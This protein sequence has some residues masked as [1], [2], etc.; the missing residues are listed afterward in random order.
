[1]LELFSDL[2]SIKVPKHRRTYQITNFERPLDYRPREHLPE[3]DGVVALDL[4]TH[5]PGL[6][7][8]RGSSWVRAGEGKI[9]GIGIGGSSGNADERFYLPVAHAGGNGDAERYFRWLAGQ[10]A[11]PSVSFVY[12]N[13]P[14]DLGW[15]SKRHGIEFANAP[16]DVQAMAALL[17]ETRYSYSLDA[18]G[19]DHLGRGKNDDD[20]K[21]ACLQGR[22]IDPMSRMDLVPAWLAEKYGL[23][24]ID[25]TIGLFNHLMPMIQR[26]GLGRVLGLERECALVAVDMKALGVRVDLDRA[27]R[28]E[29]EFSLRRAEALKRV[30]DLTGVHTSAS[31]LQSLIKALKVERPEVHLPKTP[32]GKESIKDDVLEALPSSPVVDAIREARQLDK[33]IGTFLKSYI[34]G[35]VYKGRI[36]ADFNPLRRSDETG[37]G[38]AT[39]GRWSSQNPNMQNIPVRT[40][41]GIEI[42]KCFVAELGEMWVK[43]DYASQ[44]PRLLIHF[45]DL[46]R[47]KGDALRGAAEMVARF[48][49]NPL[50]DLHLQTAMLMFGH[51]PETWEMLDKALRKALRS[52]AKT[53]NLA[54]AY[55]AG[56]G[57]ICDQLG[58][59]TVMKSFVKDGRTITYRAA[60]DE[61]QALLDKHFRAM[62]FLKQMQQIAKERAEDLGM[63][64]TIL[65]R[66]IRF[67][68]VG[69]DILRPHKALNAAVQ[70]SAADQ[71]KMAQ[72]ALRREKI[73]MLVAV[74]DEADLSAPRGADAYIARIRAIMEGVLPLRVPVVAEAKFADNWGDVSVD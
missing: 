62:P 14:Y 55:G 36:H 52:R 68:R 45:A 61:G 1:V 42:R 66:I 25:L 19:R 38:G 24:D 16:Y 70:G 48:N 72:V 54:I 50:T 64:R 60:G 71:M 39:G 33:A 32:T 35:N 10:A 73:P 46:T 34:F 74:H 37:S 58:L 51:T 8:G 20:L 17:D 67:K 21:K 49:E 7:E 47:Y 26:E 29:K 43:L 65:G 41:I 5:D 63:I 40:A 15:L 31:D 22:L 57:N 3:L 59:P 23:N 9:C 30:H 28:L 4:E 12:A 56:G 13:A 11:K 53:I 18:L 44:E 69:G 6:S 2:P 27:E